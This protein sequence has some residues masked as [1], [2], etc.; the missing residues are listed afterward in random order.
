MQDENLDPLANHG[1]MSLPDNRYN[2]NGAEC[3]R[4]MT[5]MVLGPEAI[6][7]TPGAQAPRFRTSIV[8]LC[9]TAQN[10]N[11]R[12][13]QGPEVEPDHLTDCSTIFLPIRRRNRFI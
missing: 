6:K 4:I 10:R 7:T 1:A 12:H 5:L 2:I 8:H 13:D 11:G 3:N 9:R